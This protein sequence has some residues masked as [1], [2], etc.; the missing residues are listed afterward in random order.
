MDPH[1]QRTLAKAALVALAPLLLALLELFHPHPH[2]DDLL[3]VQVN[4]WLFVHYAQI[5]LFPLAALA[6][7][8]LL[9][10]MTGLTAMASRA[11]LFVFAI[12][13]VAFDTAAGVAT[14]ILVQ[15]AHASGHP[16]TWRAAIDAI[17]LH[18]IV[19]GVRQDHIPSLSMIG[20]ATLSIGTVAAAVTLKHAGRSWPPVLLLGVSGF[21]LE[22]FNT[23]SWPGGPLTFG[24]IAVAAAWLEWQAGRATAANT[25]A[26]TRNATVIP[27]PV[28]ERRR[29]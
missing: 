20:A 4:T 12:C 27:R 23:H 15:A 21:G 18:P 8:S 26:I 28:V 17:W 11:A 9:R 10:G 2:A 25:V 29:G 24:G 14:G 13:F 5:V 16:E 6:V 19:G 1:E 3:A 22:V 7:V